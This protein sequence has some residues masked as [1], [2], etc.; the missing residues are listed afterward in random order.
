MLAGAREI[1]WPTW[2]AVKTRNRKLPSQFHHH[3]GLF[4]FLYDWRYPDFRC[5]I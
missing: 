5:R 2:K 4:L 1:E 3:G